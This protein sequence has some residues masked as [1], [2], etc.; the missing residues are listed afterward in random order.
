MSL[1]Y[2]NNILARL[3]GETQME[4]T[5]LGFCDRLRDDATL[6]KFYN[7]VSSSNLVTMQHDAIDYAFLVDA[8]ETSS[9]NYADYY[10]KLEGRLLLQHYRLLDA[11]LS[12]KHFPAIREHFMESLRESW[13][14]ES[15]VEEAAKYFDSLQ[16]VFGTL[17]QWNESVDRTETDVLRTSIQQTLE[18]H[19]A[20][21]SPESSPCASPIRQKG[22]RRRSSKERLAAL[23]QSL[24]KRTKLTA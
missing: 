15:D 11:G 12:V 8:D 14:Q 21:V 2:K 18:Q 1:Q 10:E 16:F 7:E 13:V 4:M 5:I 23:F 22:A 24:N 3:G 19:T 20:V 17:S 6:N 9:D